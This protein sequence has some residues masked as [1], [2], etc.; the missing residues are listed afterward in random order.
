MLGKKINKRPRKIIGFKTPKEII[1][2]ELKF[3]AQASIK[4]QRLLRYKLEC[5]IK[6]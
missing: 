2:L 3:V 1:E 5:S 4:K 6:L